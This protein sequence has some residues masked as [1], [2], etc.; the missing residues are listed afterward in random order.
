MNLTRSITLAGLALS[1]IACSGTP[2]LSYAVLR[3]GNIPEPTFERLETVTNQRNTQLH[4]AETSPAR[5]GGTFLEPRY[6]YIITPPF[7]PQTTDLRIA[8]FTA[9]AGN[10]KTTEVAGN[11]QATLVSRLK[12]QGLFHSV[13]LFNPNTQTAPETVVMTGAV[14]QAD[15]NDVA[16]SGN[17]HTQTEIVLYQNNAVKGA[18]VLN[19][20]QLSG[21]TMVPSA[22]VMIGMALASVTQGSRAAW[23]ADKVAHIMKKVQKGELEGI[24]TSSGEATALKFTAPAP[25]VQPVPAIPASSAP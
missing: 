23:T 9:Y 25:V 24:D 14:N 8:P 22:A 1:L 10:S 2:P 13:E 15:S 20:S 19:L 7:T 12:S 5:T 4:R 6:V 11:L 18:I 3:T 16:L 21:Y 17:A